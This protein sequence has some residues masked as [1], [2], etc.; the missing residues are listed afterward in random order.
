MADFPIEMPQSPLIGDLSFSR[1]SNSLVFDTEV[2]DPIERRRFTG[3]RKTINIS[4]PQCSQAAKDA[5]DNFYDNILEDGSL[6]FTYTDFE[7]GETGV[8]FKFMDPRPT[9][10][11]TIPD[12]L[13]DMQWKISAVLRR[14]F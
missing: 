11:P 14:I 1:I 6:Y 3:K 7:T 9:A 5:F 4:W 12:A 2:G 13:G 8:T 10:I